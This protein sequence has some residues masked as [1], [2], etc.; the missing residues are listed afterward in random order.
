MGYEI[1]DLP[2]A[3]LLSAVAKAE[4]WLLLPDFN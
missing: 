1:G 4:V 3:A 2:L